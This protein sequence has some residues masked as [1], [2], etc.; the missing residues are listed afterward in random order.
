M[1]PI[2]GPTVLIL[3]DNYY[4]GWQAID[5]RCGEN[6]PIYPANLTFRAMVL[7]EEREY[8]LELRYWPSWLTTALVISL[9]GLAA[10]VLLTFL[11]RRKIRTPA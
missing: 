5:A 9:C 6:I 4:P 2:S 3:N 11:G 10:L 1:E 8:Q 7:P